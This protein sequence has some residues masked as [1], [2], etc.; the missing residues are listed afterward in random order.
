MSYFLI[1]VFSL[2]LI[3]SS[4]A[5]EKTKSTE[6]L[7]TNN[8]IIKFLDDEQGVYEDP[9]DTAKDETYLNVAYHINPSVS[10]STIN[11]VMALT[12]FE[13]DYIK[14]S[15]NVWWKSHFSTTS[16]ENSIIN[17]GSE[18]DTS[19]I[20]SFGFGPQYR[21]HLL[22]NFFNNYQIFETVSALL[23]YNIVTDSTIEEN[24]TGIGLKSNFGIHYRS[25]K[26]THYGIV[27]SYNLIPAQTPDK[28]VRTLTWFS[29]G[30]EVGMYF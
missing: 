7:D 3:N 21:F 19:S 26:K 25:S 16:A 22:Q 14:K 27:V 24:L 4:L 23:T 5:S 18:F 13:G 28:I 12:T 8:V 30:F 6:K 10:F 17:E 2:L 29:L 11:K 1:L 15:N 20:L 9:L